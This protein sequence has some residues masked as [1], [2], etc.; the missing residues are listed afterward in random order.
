MRLDRWMITTAAAL[1]LLGCGGGAS[2]DASGEA[3]TSGGE[4]TV[5]ENTNA[6]PPRYE[7]GR[8]EPAGGGRAPRRAG[9]GRTIE[10]P[11]SA[12]GPRDSYLYVAAEFRC[13]DGGNPLGGDPMA[14]ARARVGNVGEN[15]TGHIIDLYRVPCAS[16][17]VDVYVDMYG[18]PEMRSL[19]GE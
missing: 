12:C 7:V 14:G 18:C 6:P 17:P 16:G 4:L 13:P 15:S 8:D 10:D 9:S 5:A 2:D 19:L 1:T 3:A 11:V